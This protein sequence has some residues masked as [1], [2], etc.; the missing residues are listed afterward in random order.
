MTDIHRIYT[1]E[2]T[3]RIQKLI[4]TIS[5]EKLHKI[6]ELVK[7]AQQFYLQGKAEKAA[8]IIL[9]TCDG[10]EIEIRPVVPL[11]IPVPPGWTG[12]GKILE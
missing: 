3:K 4:I 2:D 5:P 6:A 9:D 10:M 7:E 8:K 12:V 11:G 1:S